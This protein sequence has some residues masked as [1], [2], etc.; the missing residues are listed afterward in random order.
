MMNNRI[1]QLRLALNMTQEEFAS[2][3]GVK[4]NTVSVYESGRNLSLIHI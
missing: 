3:I 4:R 2:Y 1:K